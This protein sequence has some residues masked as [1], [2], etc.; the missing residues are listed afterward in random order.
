MTIAMKQKIHP[1]LHP[2]VLVDSST[3]FELVSRST[4]K[5]KETR[6]I[7]GVEHFV[8]HMEISSSS[9]PF[10]TGKQKLIDTARRVDRYKKIVEKSEAKVRS[11]LA[12]KKTQARTATKRTTAA[13]GS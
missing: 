4:M 2:V 7:D 9:H 13:K 3:G 12:H 6:T 1:I 10:Y 8:I 11:T 5:S